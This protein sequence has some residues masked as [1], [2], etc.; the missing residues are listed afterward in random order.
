VDHGND[1]RGLDE[2]I[3]PD[4]RHQARGL[5][6]LEEI[7]RRELAELDRD[8]EVSARPLNAVERNRLR[9]EQVPP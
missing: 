1:T 3:V 9:A 2:G 7:A 5:E 4:S 8:V 6:I